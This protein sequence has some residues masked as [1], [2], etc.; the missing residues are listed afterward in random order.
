MARAARAGNQVV[1]IFIDL[2]R[3]KIVNDARGHAT[4]DAMLA[5][6]AQR[7][8][9]LTRQSD[10]LARF[11]GDEFVIVCEDMDA[12]AA[13]QLTSRIAGA[14]DEPFVIDGEEI[15]AKVSIGIAFSESGDTAESLLRKSDTAMY[16]VK[17]SGRRD[18]F[19]FH[20]SMQQKASQRMATESQLRGALQRDELRLRF[21]PIVDLRTGKPAGFEALVRW[22]HPERGLL[23]PAEF[24]P[25]AHASGL[26]VDIDKW[27]LEHAARQ[28][29]EW[30]SGHLTMG[31]PTVAVNLST[32]Y[33]SDRSF[34]TYT[35]D[36][37]A[38]TGIEPGQ[39]HFEITEVEEIG[40]I[41]LA[42]QHMN[43]ATKLGV[44]FGVDDFGAGHSSLCYLHRLPVQTLK[45]DKSFV[46]GLGNHDPR[47]ALIIGAV[48]DLAHALGIE[49]IGEGVE[50]KSQLDE[51]LR[52]GCDKAQGFFWSK[53]LDPSAGPKWLEEHCR[54]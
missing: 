45:M 5:E 16:E 4:G 44:C 15:F 10:V 39:L 26:I 34:I 23:S 24:L 11:G 37:L 48:I 32:R 17:D 42:I 19:V 6:L 31:S 41:D 30:G 22:E 2:D 25:V 13:H 21:Q 29:R 28:L 47:P 53:P 51:L 40:D 8:T 49:V 7:L 54:G 52:L 50:R 20:E 35:K 3:F 18:A 38:L 46:Q 27:V 12:D 36:L 1:V 43:E 9:K 14:M 33:L